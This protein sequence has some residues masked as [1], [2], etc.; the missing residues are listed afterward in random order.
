[1]DTVC[2]LLPTE[3]SLHRALSIAR[4]GSWLWTAGVAAAGGDDLRRPTVAWIAVIAAFGVAVAGTM[5]ARTSSTP[6]DRAA[7][8]SEPTGPRWVGGVPFALIQAAVAVGLVIADGW[9]FDRGHSFATSQNLAAASPT[10]AAVTLGVSLGVV[11]GAVGGA[12]VGSARLLGALA[13]GVEDFT[14]A[15]WASLVSSVV[16]IGLAGG[17]AGWLAQ[18][19]RRV[20]TEVI[21][22][23]ERDNVARAMH[24]TVLQT[25]AHV[26]RR[27]DDTQLS[28]LARRTDGEIR[29]FLYGPPSSPRRTLASAVRAAASRAGHPFGL[30]VVVN[31]V[32]DEP[33][34][35]GP[36][37]EAIA[38]AV[39]E[40]VTNAGKHAGDTRVVVYAESGD[41]GL[42]ASVR[43]EG[44]GFD[45]IA[46]T[47][48][49]GIRS[50]IRGPIENVGGRVEIE[51]SDPRPDGGTEV[52]MWVP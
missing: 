16:F 23:R 39:G 29:Q 21:V 43:D 1:M 31:V 20:E 3:L 37:V 8:R 52:R 38:A 27:S 36:R 25:L 51:S 50:S 45:P 9:A 41:G 44:P 28:A 32:D 15:R 22:R 14:A 19:L 42:F 24:D 46:S 10:I 12:V 47:T 17:V 13:N 49:Q 7:N 30:D 18:T 26:A 11:P 35:T 2:R 5:G 4:W 6:R 40:A 34:T 33:P 48:G